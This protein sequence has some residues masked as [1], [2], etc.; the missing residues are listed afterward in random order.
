MTLTSSR[1]ARPANN[2]APGENLLTV[3]TPSVTLPQGGDAQR[4]RRRPVHHTPRK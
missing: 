1:F 3:I 4:L 2:L